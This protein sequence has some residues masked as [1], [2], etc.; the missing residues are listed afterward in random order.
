MKRTLLCVAAALAAAPAFAQ[1]HVDARRT[2]APDA[3][4]Q[5]ENSNGSVK[6]IGWDRNEVQVTGSLGAK[7]EGLDFSGTERRLSI[8]VDASNPHAVTSDLEIHVP[9]GSRLEI[10][11]YTAGITV[12]GVTGT[13]N[14]ESVNGSVDV[15]GTMR[16]VNAETVDGNVSVTCRCRVA[17]AQAVNGNVT[18]RGASGEVEASTVNGTLVVEGGTFDRAS[19]ETVS[20]NLRLSGDLAPRANVT[21]ETVSGAVEVTLPAAVAADFTITTFSGEVTNDLGPAPRSTSR[22]TSQKELEFSTGKGGAAVDVQ[23][24]SGDI[25]LRKR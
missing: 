1:Q 10:E 15:D 22:Y 14:A 24:L 20:G 23:T 2:A 9:A 21:I 17:H 18:V 11:T 25:R 19:L 4:I 3:L 8:E 6:V 16:E 12:T 7:A 13:L 5:I